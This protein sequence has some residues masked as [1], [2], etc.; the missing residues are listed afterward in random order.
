MNT[1][2]EQA[3]S[4]TLKQSVIDTYHGIDVVD[5]YRWL[6][7]ADDPVVCEWTATQNRYTRAILDAIPARAAI[8][9]R[10]HE[11]YTASS[12]D[13]YALSKRGATLFAIKLQPPKEQPLLVAFQSVDDLSS[14]RVILDPNALDPSGATTIDFYVPS[15]D[16]SLVAVSLSENGS[17]EGALHVCETATGRDLGDLI[18]RV[19]YPTAGG[20][21]AWNADSTGFFYTRYPRG[22]ERP[23]ED[24]NFYQQ[25]YFHRLGTPTEED[26]YEIGRAFPRIAEVELRPSANYRYLLA[27][28]ANGDGGEYAHFLRDSEGNWSQ[29]TRFED[30]IT[31]AEFGLDDTL[32][33]LSHQ[34]ASR[35]KVLRLSLANPTLAFAQTVIA[36]GENAIQRVTPT[37]SRLYVTELTGGPSHIRVYGHNGDNQGV[38]P[39]EPVSSIGEALHLDNDTIVFRSAS[40]IMPP[41][42]Y[43]F[44]P[45]DEEPVKTALVATSPA[46]FSDVE[47]TRAF[48][49]SK[50]GV[51]I[52]LN[53]IHRKGITLNG[54]NPTI[55]Y[56]YGGYGISLTPTFN[57]RRRLWMDYG[58]VYV[59]ANLRGGGEYGEDWHL[60]GSL[61]KK[62]NVFDDFIASAEY[63]I[64]NGYTQPAKLAIEGRSNGGL[65]MGAALTQ[66]PDLFRA[67]IAHVGIYD[68]L[69]VEL[70]PNGAFNVT[71]FGTVQNREQFE[72]L[73]AYSPLHRV[74]DGV[75]YPAVMF[76]TGENDGRVDPANSRRMTARLQ[77]ATSS[78]WPVLLRTSASAGHGIGTALNERVAED[79]DVF[80]FLIDQLGIA[81]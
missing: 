46:D 56:G 76:V 44:D 54:A 31:Q 5:E 64:N 48:A 9:R 26:T 24:F 25:V 58:G 30:Q 12:A 69:R 23:P 42:W 57:V 71:E 3:V 80:A 29:I 33:L 43:R 22:N 78:G 36:Q 27:S 17:E 20:D 8:Y 28:V 81:L 11:L 63:L 7:D 67:V 59:I 47:V 53:I 50:D 73:Y 32:Y 15:R 38:L 66:R 74:V 35:G 68:M 18:P 1:S 52:P 70:H 45:A 51:Q 49:S 37:A 14:E 21:V 4:A 60:A 75:A 34:N 10:L 55:L 40:F 61:T 77:A 13:Y 16:G 41:A 2:N 62:Q 79:A 39:L 19:T 72:A 6:E 65:L